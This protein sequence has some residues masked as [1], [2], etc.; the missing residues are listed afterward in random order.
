MISGFRNAVWGSRLVNFPFDGYQFTW[1][2]DRGTKHWV[3]EK[4][5]RIP[6]NEG[7]LN[8]FGDACATSITGRNSNHLAIY[9]KF[10]Q[11]EKTHKKTKFKFKN[12]WLKEKDCRNVVERAW[13]LCENQ[14]LLERLQF[15]CMELGKWGNHLRRGFQRCIE[16]CKRRMARSR[17]RTDAAGLAEFARAEFAKVCYLDLL[18]K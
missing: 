13:S 6:V 5:Y 12:H 17:D 3:E 18:E 9:L 4:L 7:W 1:E 14:V 11:K 10:C 8:I 15:C 2:R 16:G